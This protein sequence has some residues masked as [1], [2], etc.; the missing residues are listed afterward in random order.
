[1]KNVGT[2]EHGAAWIFQVWAS[3]VLS[4]SATT[5]GIIYLPV[6]NWT[7]SLM[8]RGLA[9]S[10]GSTLSL[11]KTTRGIHEAKRLTSKVGEARVEKLLAEH[12]PFYQTSLNLLIRPRVD[13]GA[14]LWQRRR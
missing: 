5:I 7:K 10:V 1:M 14:S 4:V 9:F 8:G 11:A 3:F 2:R 13:F 12:H 6:D